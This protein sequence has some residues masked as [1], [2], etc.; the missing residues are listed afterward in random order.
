ME[1]ASREEHHVFA[2]GRAGS[3]FPKEVIKTGQHSILL[4]RIMVGD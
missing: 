3:R 2:H 4:R 1:A